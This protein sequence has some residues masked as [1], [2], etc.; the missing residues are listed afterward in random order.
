MLFYRKEADDRS[1]QCYCGSTVAY[2]TK[3]VDTIFNGEIR[4]VELSVGDDDQSHVI[5]PDD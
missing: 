2:K 1:I 4:W 5:E 3:A